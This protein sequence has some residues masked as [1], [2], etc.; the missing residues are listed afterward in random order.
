MLG[1]TI[2]ECSEDLLDASDALDDPD[3]ALGGGVGGRRVP[4]SV[5]LDRERDRVLDLR[6]FPGEYLCEDGRFLGRPLDLDLDLEHERRRR[7]DLDLDLWP[8]LL[9]L[10][11]RTVSTAEASIIAIGFSISF[12]KKP[13][14]E[15]FICIQ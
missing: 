12:W 14:T 9:G 3:L 8:D 11:S 6:R 4:P 13:E 5:P 1:I 2:S 7:G 15:S 10:L